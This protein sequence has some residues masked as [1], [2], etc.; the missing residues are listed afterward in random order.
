MTLQGVPASAKARR[1]WQHAGKASWNAG[2]EFVRHLAASTINRKWDR[3][4]ASIL[5]MLTQC[6]QSLV[7]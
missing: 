3:P 7:K 4:V 6:L 5:E 2:Q 1:P